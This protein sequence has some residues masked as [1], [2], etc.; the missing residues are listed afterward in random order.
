MTVAAHP[1]TA[2]SRRGLAVLRP[3]ALSVEEA[4]LGGNGSVASMM[5]FGGAAE[6]QIDTA[7]GTVL[8]SVSSPHPST[9]LQPGT[10][11][12]LTVAAD[13]VYLLPM[14]ESH[15]VPVGEDLTVA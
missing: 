12:L 6:Y 4:N 13:L 10:R 5:Y 9:L 2:G 15:S 7:V 1:D 8:V 14:S 3:E 11:V